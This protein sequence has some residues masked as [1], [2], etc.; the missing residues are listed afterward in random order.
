M[1]AYDLLVEEWREYDF[2][3][4]IY[5][6]LNPKTLFIK[7]GGTTHRILDSDDIVHCVP[8][9]GYN[10]CVLRWKPRDL[11]NPVNF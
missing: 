6:I 5:R 2:N 3:N 4:R 11:S 9:P 1:K 7:E 10:G 8:A